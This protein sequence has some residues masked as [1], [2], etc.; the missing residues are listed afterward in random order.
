MQAIQPEKL[1]TLSGTSAPESPL[2]GDESGKLEEKVQL[3]RVRP[4]AKVISLY[5]DNIFISNTNRVAD[6]IFAVSAGLSFEI[7]DF[8]D[9]KDNYLTA[10]YVG[11]GMLYLKN[12]QENAYNQLAALDG[13]YIW[14]KLAVQLSSR[15]EYL[16]TPNRDIGGLVKQSLFDNSL[17]FVYS[18]S[19]KTSADFELR[20]KAFIYVNNLNSYDYAAK[21]GADY[22][23]TEKLALGA[24]GVGGVLDAQESPT[25]YYQQFR[26]RASYDATG[27]LVFRLSAGV[28]TRELDDLSQM[29]IDPVFSLGGDYS[30][31]PSTTVSFEAYR[32]IQASA[33]ASGQD[34]V[35]TGFMVGIEQ[36][37][38]Q[39]LSA[40]LILG[41]ENDTYF[42][43]A[44]QN[45]VD[46]IDNYAFVRPEI[47]TIFF[48]NYKASI[49]YEFRRDNSNQATYSF[50]DNR[51]G[52]E[53]GA[54]F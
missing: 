26:L 42:A 52:I 13:Q 16:S 50:Y 19:D 34:F 5:D 35:G 28:E 43:T 15:Y 33:S 48:T 27:K 32:R 22:Q 18:H 2:S 30:P 23:I 6:V 12:S 36:Q 47:S 44:G 11:T 24:E 14:N 10:Q 37:F 4:I 1:D 21:L 54:K 38:L 49:F 7:G 45:N 51:A 29:R 31:F 41:Y 9:L 20:Q 17:R 25:Q 3:W 46:R 39:K 8:R 53:L 40:K